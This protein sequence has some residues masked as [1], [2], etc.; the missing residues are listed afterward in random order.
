MDYDQWKQQ[1]LENP[2]VD[3]IEP[4]VEQN[5]TLQKIKKAGDVGK[6]EV[7]SRVTGQDVPSRNY[8]QTAR[9]VTQDAGVVNWTDGEQPG[10]AD[11]LEFTRQQ[12]LLQFAPDYAQA[13]AATNKEL[14]T[15]TPIEDLPLQDRMAKSFDAIAPMGGATGDKNVDDAMNDAVKASESPGSR[16]T[17]DGGE[18]GEMGDIS[19]QRHKFQPE[20]ELGYEITPD[21]VGTLMALVADDR[22]GMSIAQR[23][24]QKGAT[25]ATPINRPESENP[26][27]ALKYVSGGGGTQSPSGRDI[28]NLNPEAMQQA[29]EDGKITEE[30]FERQ[31]K[32][33]QALALDDAQGLQSALFQHEVSEDAIDAV[34]QYA[35]LPASLAT[36]GLTGQ[37][38][39]DARWT[40]AYGGNLP[41]SMDK[42]KVKGAPDGVYNLYEMSKDPQGK[43]YIAMAKKNRERELIRTWLKQGGRDAYAH[44]E[45]IRSFLDMN[46]EHINNIAGEGNFDHPSNWV[47]ASQELNTLKN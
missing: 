17:I 16:G 12:A 25:R 44:H 14:E 40:K 33:L 20:M 47:W 45:G 46:L 36:R 5:P 7:L 29:L 18:A 43:K 8:A 26:I 13:K 34:Y 21:E 11:D 22:A 31:M 39:D 9:N 24:D 23:G 15:Q 2:R 37:I 30:Q 19:Y 28:E 6:R 41:A 4:G 32:V 35:D 27:N 3:T 10:D 1:L 38:S 42:F